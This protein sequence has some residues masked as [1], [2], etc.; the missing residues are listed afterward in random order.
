MQND[1]LERLFKFAIDVILFL[2][3]IEN[4]EEYR[5]LKGN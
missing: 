4:T 2:R 5:I 3:K 1:L